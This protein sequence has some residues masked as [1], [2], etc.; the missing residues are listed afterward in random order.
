[1]PADIEARREENHQDRDVMG[2]EVMG[3]EHIHAIL[4]PRRAATQRA[5]APVM[6]PSS[7]MR[8]QN[9]ISSSTSI[10]CNLSMRA[11][12]LFCRA[13]AA[14]GSAVKH[15]RRNRNEVFREKGDR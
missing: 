3:Q 14:Q 6:M 7:S 10:S 13:Q 1:M 8:P 5:T 9:T 2:F 4:L 12:L 11:D 15:L